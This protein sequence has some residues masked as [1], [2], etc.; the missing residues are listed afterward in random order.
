MDLNLSQHREITPGTGNLTNCPELVKSWI[1]EDNSK[2]A[3]LLI[4]L[5][6]FVVIFIGKC[7]FHLS[8]RKLFFA[9]DR[10][11]YRKQQEPKRKV[12]EPGPSGYI[13]KTMSVLKAKE[14]VK[15]M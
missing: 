13:Y 15:R 6:M 7:S 1:L 11:Y 12:V 5:Q 10:E 3:P 2:P 8:S 14:E 4:T 9:T